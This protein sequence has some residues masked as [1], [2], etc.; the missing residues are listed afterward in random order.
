M[1]AIKGGTINDG[2]RPS[3]TKTCGKVVVVSRKVTWTW[4]HPRREGLGNIRKC[5]CKKNVII[6]I[7]RRE[8]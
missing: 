2:E 1:A 6:I 3:R 4:T 8:V 7:F 5:D